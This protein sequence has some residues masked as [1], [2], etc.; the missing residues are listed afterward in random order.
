V[1]FIESLTIQGVHHQSAPSYTV[2]SESFLTALTISG[3]LGYAAQHFSHN[4]LS[5][6]G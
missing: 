6:A 3:S 4:L 5:I 2:L 1:I